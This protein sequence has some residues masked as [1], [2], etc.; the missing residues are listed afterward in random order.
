MYHANTKKLEP[1]ITMNDGVV[2]K[3]ARGR[4]IKEDDGARGVW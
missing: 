2:I 3:T 4:D 1:L